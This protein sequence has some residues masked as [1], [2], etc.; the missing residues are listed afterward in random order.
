MPVKDAPS[1]RAGSAKNR[2]SL[3]CP[4]V[5]L[6][7]EKDAPEPFE[8]VLLVL[9]VRRPKTLSTTAQDFLACGFAASLSLHCTSSVRCRVRWK[10]HAGWS[11]PPEVCLRSPLYLLSRDVW[12]S[13]DRITDSA[14]IAW[15]CALS[16]RV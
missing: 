6:P 13:R 3:L 4:N 8:I 7:T 10:E 16:L 12:Q 11:A 5:G 2:L 9:S 15:K 14:R 1:A